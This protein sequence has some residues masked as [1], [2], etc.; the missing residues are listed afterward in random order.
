MSRVLS[1]GQR[2]ILD[3]LP[4]SLKKRFVFGGGTALA[5]YYLSHRLS[6]DLDFF[7]LNRKQP[8]RLIEI[9]GILKNAGFEIDSVNKLFDRCVYGIRIYDECIKTEFVPLYFSRLQ[10][11]MECSRF[12]LKIESLRDLAANKIMAMSERFEIKD[13]VDVYAISRHAGW[14]FIDMMKFAEA[15]ESL[16]YRYVVHISRIFAYR[17]ELNQIRFIEPFDV[18]QI[19][20]FYKRSDKELKSIST[21]DFE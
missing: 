7:A 16:P 17:E 12:N 10:T 19:L 8:V 6:E 15:K 1:K 14:R 2:R 20:D 9:E 5:E 18:D 4:V 13:F 3:L 21:V 11:P